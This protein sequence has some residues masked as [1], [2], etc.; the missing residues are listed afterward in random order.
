MAI[1]LPI[2]YAPRDLQS[3]ILSGVYT[4]PGPTMSFTVN[5][6]KRAESGTLAVAFYIFQIMDYL[7]KFY[8]LY[9]IIRG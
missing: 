5:I 2:G 1:L 3:Q 6:K 8:D 9:N 7:K 4:F